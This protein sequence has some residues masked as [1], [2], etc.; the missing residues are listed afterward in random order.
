MA[1]FDFVVE[2]GRII[3]ISLIADARSCKLQIGHP[4]L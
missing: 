2:N 3:E 1:V 4:L